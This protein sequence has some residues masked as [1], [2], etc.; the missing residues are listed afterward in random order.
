MGFCL[1]VSLIVTDDHVQ[2][3]ESQVYCTCTASAQLIEGRTKTV[4]KICNLFLNKI[5]CITLHGS[6][7][8]YGNATSSL[9]S[10]SLTI[11]TR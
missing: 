2:S 6:L 10:H 7:P 11:T 4:A 9:E 8:L 5:H 1:V 3:V